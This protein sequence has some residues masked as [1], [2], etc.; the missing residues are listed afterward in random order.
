M[1]L[2]LLS[3]CSDMEALVEKE[4]DGGSILRQ[5]SS[6]QYGRVLHRGNRLAK[7]GSARR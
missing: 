1:S 3:S 5:F 2:K 7:D 4:T 6:R